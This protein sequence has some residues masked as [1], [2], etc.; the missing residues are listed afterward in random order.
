[1]KRPVEPGRGLRLTIH[2]LSDTLRYG[3]SG[4]SPG[5]RTGDHFPFE[6]WLVTVTHELGYS[7][8]VR[9]FGVSFA[10]DFRSPPLL[11]GFP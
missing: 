3:G 7:G 10:E 5:L 2:F 6:V 8:T 11:R 4:N 9:N 1:M